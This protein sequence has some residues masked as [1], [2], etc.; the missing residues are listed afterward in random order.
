[1]KSVT[2]LIRAIREISLQLAYADRWFVVK[3][4]KILTT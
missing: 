3:K 1:M 2:F 4:Q